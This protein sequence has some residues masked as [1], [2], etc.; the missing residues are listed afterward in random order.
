MISGLLLSAALTL[1]ACGGG[2]G[3]SPMATTTTGGT[4]T[5]TTGGTT[6][7]TTGSTGTTSGTTGTTGSGTNT[8][9]TGATSPTTPPTLFATSTTPNFTSSPPATGTVFPLNQQVVS[10][11]TNGVNTNY[12]PPT[13]ATLT[14]VGTQ[15]SGASA[16]PLYKLSLPGVSLAG[17]DSMAADGSTTGLIFYVVPNMTYTE[18]GYWGMKSSDNGSYMGQFIAGYQT[19]AA[20]VPTGGTATYIGNTGLPNSPNTG[21]LTGWSFYPCGT[22]V[23]PRILENGNVNIGVNFASGTVTGSV[24]SIMSGNV[25]LDQ[26]YWN[27]INLSGNMSGAAMSGKVTLSN[28]GASTAAVDGMATGTTGTFNGALYGPGGQELGMTWSVAEPSTGKSAFGT[29]TATK[30]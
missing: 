19:P 17:A 20:N 8:G 30:Q 4:T 26:H 7:G 14:L 18:A 11:D 13:T 24:T 29:I 10:R 27:D 12:T 28:T 23:C 25:S 16:V 9:T 2:G 3:S 22:S 15:G 21:Q 6:S 1:S 5:G